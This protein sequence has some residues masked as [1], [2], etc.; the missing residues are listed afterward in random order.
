MSPEQKLAQERRA[1]L[2]AERLLD[3]K[4]R[5]LIEANRKLADHS[6]NLTDEIFQTR[7][8]AEKLKG[9]NVQV[10]SELENVSSAYAIAERRLW[11]SIEA[12]RDGFAVFD[13][14]TRMVAANASYLGLFDGLTEA[15]LGTKYSD[16]MQVAL[17][18][19]LID[20]QGEALEKVQQD[21]HQR[22][23]TSHIPD[24][25]LRFWNGRYI[26]MVDRRT[27]DGGVVSLCIDLTE[28]MR[29]WAAVEAI[30]DGFV[31]FDRDDQLVMC[32]DR[33]KEIYSESAPAM[34]PGNSFENILR[35]GAERGQYREAEGRIEDWITE[36]L[37]DHNRADRVVEQ[38]LGDGRWLRILE[39]STPDGGRVGLRVDITEQKEQQKQLD[40]ARLQAEAASRAKSAF[41]ANMSHE[42]RTPMN[43][44]VGMADLLCDTDLSEEQRLYADTI[45]TS[46]EAL[47]GLLNDV[48]DFS[49]IEAGKLTIQHESFDLERTAHEVT[50]LLQA[51]ARDKAL[52]LC[53]DYDLFLPTLFVGDRGR[54]RQVLT[55]LIGNAVKF[56]ESGHVL[57]RVIGLDSD[58]QGR[59]RVHV[60]VEDTGI[61]IARDMQSHIFGEFNQIEDQ[62]NRKYEGTGLGLAITRQLVEL[63][64]GE[65]WVESEL[66]QGSCFGFSLIL[67]ADTADQPVSLRTMPEGLLAFVVDDKEVNRTI[68]DRQLQKLGL[69]IQLFTCA[70]DALAA[71]NNGARPN[72]IISDE[73][74]HGLSGREFAGRLL[75]NS[76]KIP[77]L[78]LTSDVAE[79]P[80]A[81]IDKVLAKPAL[82]RTLM[83]TVEELV[84]SSQPESIR[85]MRVLTA[86][87]NKTNRLVFSKMVKQLNIDLQFAHNGFEAVQAQQDWRPDLIFMDI[88]M[89]E[90]DGKAATAEIRRKEQASGA[91]PVPIVALTAHALAGDRDEILAVGL[92]DYLTKPLKRDQ[93]F[94][95]IATHC[96]EN[97]EP[98]GAETVLATAAAS[99]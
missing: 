17:S 51:T 1:R 31:L 15:Q 32:N 11:E 68:L 35:Y 3:Q 83:Q 91:R 77:F 5:E 23:E 94:S 66:G 90:M 55:N 39:K 34:L 82:R 81:G 73:K 97:A 20:P 13:A 46:G 64:G 70:E 95:A 29:M 21:L 18:E 41:F 42:L 22:L 56:T 71:L 63:M 88:S 8:Q 54:V 2:A 57:V 43:G 26:K 72:L 67:P 14:D 38:E 59:H 98:C 65:I 47:L 48:L 92:T 75:Q 33:Y 61:G 12:F 7:H 44:V 84:A 76:Q 10:K 53:I 74:M 28:M 52:N 25:T 60:T 9:E 36:R 6:R 40:Q 27:P 37:H 69:S 78:L 58:E 16:L 45:R 24:V 99:A 62:Q 93:I 49:K 87:D 85:K 30:P 80:G 79:A 86:E 4:S 96:P 89:P 19:G 50:M